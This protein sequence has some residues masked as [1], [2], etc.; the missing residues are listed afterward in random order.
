MP[1]RKFNADDAKPLIVAVN[2]FALDM[3][4]YTRGVPG[5]PR[6]RPR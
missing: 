1:F 3:G 2:G 5:P 6:W 4:W